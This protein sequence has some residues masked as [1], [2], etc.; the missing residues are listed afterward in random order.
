MNGLS[1]EQMREIRKKFKP[2]GAQIHEIRKRY[3]EIGTKEAFRYC[4]KANF[5]KAIDDIDE[6]NIGTLDEIKMI[7]H[8]LVFFAYYGNE[9]ID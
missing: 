4:L 1:T 6:G 9:E 2:T 3:P 8:G 7:L 5:G